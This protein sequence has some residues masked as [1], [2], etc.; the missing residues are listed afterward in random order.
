M[1]IK[2]RYNELKSSSTLNS[3]NTVT[4][5]NV[6]KIEASTEEYGYIY[7]VLQ[8]NKT[9]YAIIVDAKSPNFDFTCTNGLD[10]ARFFNCEG[11]FS[12]KSP[13]ELLIPIS[14]IDLSIH[15][16]DPRTLIGGKVLVSILNGDAVK[17]EYIGEIDNTGETPLKIPRTLFKSLRNYIGAYTRLDDESP[18]VEQA[19][20]LLGL[21]HELAK[22]LYE[23]D[24]K[25]WNGVV[26]RYENEAVYTND[27]MQPKDGEVIIT[28][29]GDVAKHIQEKGMKTKN[30][31]L[32]VKIFSAR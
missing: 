8:V 14:N 21:D 18:E 4:T 20:E 12:S 1:K 5:R 16:L 26:V 17:A 24:I 27:V 3:I 11:D 2:E 30:C 25:D 15:V 6:I 28:P 29:I 10:G 9:I 13:Y 23:T 32:P 31:H 22:K 19:R 7:S